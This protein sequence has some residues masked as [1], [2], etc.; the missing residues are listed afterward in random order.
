MHSSDKKVAWKI[1][2]E[3]S[4]HVPGIQVS[5]ECAMLQVVAF[6]AGVAAKE[7]ALDKNSVMAAIWHVLRL[8]ALNGGSLRCH[9][10]SSKTKEGSPGEQHFP[11]STALS[12]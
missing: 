2:M 11:H 1:C 12:I 9:S 8:L 4:L 6:I 5:C 10:K 7:E 3:G